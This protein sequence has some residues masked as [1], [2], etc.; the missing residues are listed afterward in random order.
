M[1]L[2]NIAI[3]IS[4]VCCALAFGFVMAR[5]A[6]ANEDIE[7]KF[8]SMDT[9]GDGKVS[10]DEH[11]A[12]STSKF[13]KMDANSDGKVTVSEMESAHE[14]MG[15]KEGRTEKMSS[16]EKL[17][18][19]DTNGDGSITSEEFTASAK[20]KFDKADANGDGYLTKQ[21]LKSGMEKMKESKGKAP[22]SK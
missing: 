22:S 20:T 5:G 12:Y 13:E 16:T 4:V 10:S 9:N 17:K 8:Q 6:R 1:N 7:A 18:M 14:K 2:R 15:G 19:M 21:E 11:A 3:K